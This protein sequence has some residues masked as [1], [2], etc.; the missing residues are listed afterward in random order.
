[1]RPRQPEAIGDIGEWFTA[2]A[3]KIYGLASA[4]HCRM[5]GERKEEAVQETVAITWRE[6]QK[7][8]ERGENV[9]ALLGRII[10]FAAKGVRG[11]GRLVGQ[12]PIRDVMSPARRHGHCVGEPREH[13][14]VEPSSADQVAVSVDL[15]EWLATLDPRRRE[16]AE[17]LVS[18][19]NTADVGRRR[20][21]TRAAIYLVPKDLIAAWEE[22]FGEELAV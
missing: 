7:L 19:L 21:V 12:Q 13:E 15:E 8:F 17:Q 5:R 10:E 18:G 2:N 20:G 3:E 14:R 22:H 9:V 16:I 11:G 1:M 4:Q 6:C